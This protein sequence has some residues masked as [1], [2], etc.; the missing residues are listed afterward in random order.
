MLQVQTVG[1]PLQSHP[2]SRPQ[3]AGASISTVVPPSSQVSVPRIEAIAADRRAGRRLVGAGVAGLDRARSRATIA[4]GLAAVVAS[5]IAREDAVAA[6]GRADGRLARALEVRLDRACCRA[7]IAAR[8]V[9][10]VASFRRGDDAVTA[11]PRQVVVDRV[12]AHAD[13]V[14]DGGGVT[15][16]RACAAGLCLRKGRKELVLG[17]REAAGITAVPARTAFARHFEIA[18]KRFPLALIFAATHLSTGSGAGRGDRG[19]ENK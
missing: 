12:G 2:A 19:V 9:A 5:L 16:Y 15:G 4:I 6:N 10:V 18:A 13:R 7:P 14:F 3:V 11:E 17:L 8:R 1:S